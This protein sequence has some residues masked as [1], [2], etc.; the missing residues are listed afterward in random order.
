MGKKKTKKGSEKAETVKEATEDKKM[1]TDATSTTAA[2]SKALSADA[3]VTYPT[4]KKARSFDEIA[5]DIRVSHRF[6]PLDKDKLKV[7]GFAL[8]G[9]ALRR[10]SLARAYDSTLPN[11]AVERVQKK[12]I[13]R[14]FRQLEESVKL[15]TDAIA[16]GSSKIPTS[17]ESMAIPR[18]T[19]IH[20]RPEAGRELGFTYGNNGPQEKFVNVR[21]RQIAPVVAPISFTA[22]ENPVLKAVEQRLVHEKQAATSSVTRIDSALSDTSVVEAMDNRVSDLTSRVDRLFT[23][24]D[25]GTTDLATRVD[26]LLTELDRGT[27]EAELYPDELKAKRQ[28]SLYQSIGAEY[29]Q[30]LGCSAA[31]AIAYYD[32]Y[33]LKLAWDPLWTEVHALESAPMPRVLV[34]FD[35]TIT[36]EVWNKYCRGMED[37]GADPT[38]IEKA[39]ATALIYYI[40]RQVIKSG[41]EATSAYNNMTLKELIDISG[42]T[43]AQKTYTGLVTL[44]ENGGNLVNTTL[45]KLKEDEYNALFDKW[46]SRVIS[47]ILEIANEQSEVGTVYLGT[48]STLG[49]PARVFAPG[50][51]NYGLL[52][53][54]RQEWIPESW[55]VGELVQ[56]IPLAPKET[57]RYT[58]KTVV[59]KKR[60]RKEIDNSLSIRKADDANSTRAESQIVQKAQQS[61]SFE[62]TASG[63]IEVEIYEIGANASGATTFKTSAGSDSSE[64]KRKMRQAVA[65]SAREFRSEH[66]VEVQIDDSTSVEEFSEN[67]ISNPNEEITV[68]YLFYELQ[69]RFSVTEAL[70][71]VRSVILVA[72]EVPPWTEID[73]NWI[74][75]HDWILKRCLLD[76]SFRPALDYVLEGQEAMEIKLTALKARK[77]DLSNLVASARGAV[78]KLEAKENLGE[79]D[80]HMVSEALYTTVGIDDGI[81]EDVF[82]SIFGGDEG[83]KLQEYEKRVEGAVD[84]L[85]RIEQRIKTKR[86]DL[87][88]QRNALDRAIAEYNKGVLEKHSKIRQVERLLE[89]L[90]DNILYYMKAIWSHESPDQ[91]YLRLFG[92]EVPFWGYPDDDTDIMVRV[93]SLSGTINDVLPGDAFEV[94]LPPPDPNEAKTRKLVEIADIETLLGFKGNYMIFPLRIQSYATAY[95]AQDFVGGVFDT[96]AKE[97]RDLSSASIEDMLNADRQT[98][99]IGQAMHTYAVDPDANASFSMQSWSDALAHFEAT[100]GSRIPKEI[101]VKLNDLLAAGLLSPE[102]APQRIIVPS[103]CLY[104]EAL[105]GKHPILEDFKLRHRMLDVQKVLAEHKSMELENIR[106]EARLRRLELSDKDIDQIIRIEGLDDDD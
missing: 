54:Y 82:E 85:D 71:S 79:A 53:N 38:E 106:A 36:S 52:V 88:M 11:L 73:W 55:Q 99:P 32:F 23:R 26:Q 76:D 29:E 40:F 28:V 97:D 68:T 48:P 3:M 21:W 100:G 20:L 22:P 81:I 19:K 77:D 5:E 84:R 104:I 95:M 15:I 51:I 50:S 92:H 47:E 39:A 75:R 74:K 31:D 14:V 72:N 93:R 34:G 80:L 101:E 30:E 16:S 69:R 87:T 45:M 43:T 103:D 63:G 105:P 78:Q 7:E 62:A 4:I 96:T 17:T 24:L 12:T 70:H 8:T 35:D 41:G 65:K 86:E 61:T 10:Y 56:T 94:I 46:R 49:Y 1:S 37:L 13:R 83:T 60:S 58:K 18:S 9:E 102:S 91:R 57:R 27:T 90:R 59:A 66:K 6:L 25:G 33:D 42:S 2:E 44:A 89:H 98:V 67:A 64:A